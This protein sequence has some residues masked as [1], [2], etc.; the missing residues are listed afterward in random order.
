MSIMLIA[1]LCIGGFFFWQGKF[2]F[3]SIQTEGRHVKAAGVI[4]GLVQAADAMVD[5]SVDS[6][7]DDEDAERIKANFLA[8]N[9]FIG[10]SPDDT[11]VGHRREGGA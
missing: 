7:I 10:P 4:L 1:L 2:N 11:D 9:A 8:R 5:A 6:E 3:G